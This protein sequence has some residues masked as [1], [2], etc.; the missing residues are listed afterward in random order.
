MEQTADAGHG[1]VQCT[2][3]LGGLLNCYH[4]AA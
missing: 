2:E 1:D 3:R 4:R